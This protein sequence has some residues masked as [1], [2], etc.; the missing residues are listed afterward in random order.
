MTVRYNPVMA[1]VILG[2]GVFNVVLGL[3]L[4]LLGEGR[5]L[6]LIVGVMSTVLGALM[7]GR[8]YFTVEGSTVV[9]RALAGPARREFP[10]TRLEVDGTRL[11][12][13][14]AGGGRVKLPFARWS[15]RRADWDALPQSAAR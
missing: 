6:V 14:D 12:G 10:F 11:Y 1:G 15:A 13:V 2:L 3:W 9:R 5:Y 7:L 4:L 8:P